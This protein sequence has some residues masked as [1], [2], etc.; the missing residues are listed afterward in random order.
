MTPIALDTAAI[1]DG[2]AHLSQASK[3][4]YKNKL[5]LLQKQTGQSI[6]YILTHP[7]KM[8]NHIRATNKELQT[9]KAFVAAVHT[10]FKHAPSLQSSH[11][12]AFARWES[13]ARAAN[14]AVSDRYK[15]GEATQRQTANFVPWPEIQAKLDHLAATEPASKRHLLLAMYVLEPPKRQD[16]GECPVYDVAQAPKGDA[17]DAGNYIVLDRR[18]H[19]P[20]AQAT[21][22][23]NE[24]KAGTKHKQMHSYERYES[25]LD[26][27]L[28]H[29]I[30][31]SLALE[32]RAHLF[33]D[34]RGKP[35]TNPKSFAAFSNGVL[36]KLFRKGVTVNT[37]RHS[38][39]IYRYSQGTT[40]QQ[41]EALAKAMGHSVG[42][43]SAYAYEVG[44]NKT[45]RITCTD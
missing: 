17:R 31:R 36:A 33:V 21:L 22:V 41:R 16:Y 35:Y 8:V 26:P 10:L 15:A 42:M 7:N 23:I 32:P 18:A 38:Y 39:I 20:Q 44:N 45:C 40:H 11:P 43:Q 13:H 30:V 37:L 14:K 2:I 34:S 4:Q 1:I 25:T 3:T 9:I 6:P 24:Y 5:A 27:R 12:D 29:I 19:S 28:T